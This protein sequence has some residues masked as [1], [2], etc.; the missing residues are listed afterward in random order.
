[1]PWTFYN[2]S[3]EALTNFGPVALTDLDIDGG[4][5]IGEAIVDADLFIIDNGA[6][7]TNVK[8]AASRI[9][10]YIGSAVTREGGNTSEATTTSTAATDFI[11][12][13]SLTPSVLQPVEVLCSLRR[14]TSGSAATTACGLKVNSTIIQAANISLSN[15]YWL[16]GSISTV[17]SG[18]SRILITTQITNYDA[19]IIADFARQI[20]GDGQS[21]GPSNR[22]TNTAL[23]P[24]EAITSITYQGIGESVSGTNPTLAAD[25]M[26]VYSVA[27]S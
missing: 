15:A 3:G 10:T 13:A 11:A 8:T 14:S 4:T 16:A 19:C 24:V 6:G 2:A 9:A 12:T 22:A 20:V 21:A 25:E 7:G 5:D 17:S 27:R 1:M 18:S 26:H 23:L